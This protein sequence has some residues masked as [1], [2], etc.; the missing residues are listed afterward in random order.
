[1]RMPEVAVQEART[2]NAAH[3]AAVGTKWK[4]LHQA[5][6]QRSVSAGYD[7]QARG[8]RPKRGAQG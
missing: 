6:R 8:L 2:P 5:R 3:V 1:V 7:G 4:K